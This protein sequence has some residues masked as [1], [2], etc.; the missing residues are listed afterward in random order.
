MSLVCSLEYG[1]LCDR[2]KCLIH[3]A[4]IRF[5]CILPQVRLKEFEAMLEVARVER[6]EKR[7][8]QRKARRKAEAAALKK[9]EEEKEC[10]F[11]STF[12][13]RSFD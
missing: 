3:G 11:G 1:Y 2:R 7:K 9:A 5:H 6:L 4:L 12:L 8:E 13:I 10:K